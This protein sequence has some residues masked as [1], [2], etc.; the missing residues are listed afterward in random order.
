M[1]AKF[2]LQNL[3][4]SLGAAGLG[5]GLVRGV[6]LDSLVILKELGS[7]TLLKEVR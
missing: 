7:W 6:E 1:T 5:F 3:R 2:H 4:L